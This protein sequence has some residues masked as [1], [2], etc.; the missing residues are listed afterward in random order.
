MTE[1][2]A[3]ASQ[4]IQPLEKLV[5]DYSRPDSGNFECHPLQK[6]GVPPIRRDL[7]LEGFRDPPEHVLKARIVVVKRV[8]S[9]DGEILVHTFRFGFLR[10]R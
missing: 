10:M 3:K 7:I 5:A 8:A 4:I 2:M 1:E 6:S 9:E